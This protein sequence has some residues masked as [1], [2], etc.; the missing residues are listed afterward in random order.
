MFAFV[1]RAMAVGLKAAM[2]LLAVAIVLAAIYGL[3]RGLAWLLHQFGSRVANDIGDFFDLLG[4]KMRSIFK[5]RSKKRRKK[6]VKHETQN[7]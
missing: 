5:H 1:F 7:L 3:F 6:V 2:I 4:D